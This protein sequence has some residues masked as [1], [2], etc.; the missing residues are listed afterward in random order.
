MNDVVIQEI[1]VNY[2]TTRSSQDTKNFLQM[3]ITHHQPE[4][5]MVLWADEHVYIK[6]V[7]EK[8]QKIPDRLIFNKFR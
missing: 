5:K 8:R 3:H 1:W 4:I 7:W 6:S 2:S